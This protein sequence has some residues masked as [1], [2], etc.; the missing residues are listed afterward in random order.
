M[1]K[2]LKGQVVLITGGGSGI[3]RAAAK[4]LAEEGAEVVVTGRREN[5]LVET[6][7]GIREA[8]GRAD[9]RVMNLRGQ[10]EHGPGH[11]GHSGKLRTH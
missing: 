7:A 2:Q 9:Y 4:L 3:G 8:G 11:L 6:V 10:A 5:R 1:E